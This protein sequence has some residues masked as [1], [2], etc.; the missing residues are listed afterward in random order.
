MT[1]LTIY[2]II[3]DIL[4]PLWALLLPFRSET[5]YTHRSRPLCCFHG[6]K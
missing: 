4:F 1:L 6:N 5:G 3:F 2:L